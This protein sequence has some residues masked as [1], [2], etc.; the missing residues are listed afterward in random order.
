MKPEEILKIPEERV[1]ELL[2][3]GFKKRVEV[4]GRAF[5]FCSII[6]AKSGI[7]NGGCAFCAQA[8]PKKTKAPVYPLVDVEEMVEGALKAKEAKAVKYSIVTSGK[9]LSEKEFEKIIDAVKAIKSRV[10]IDVDVSLGIIPED[11]LKELKESGVRRVHHNLE[12]SKEFYPRITTK[13]D[14]QKKFSFAKKVKEAGLEL[15]CGGLF[16][17]G[18]SERDWV[19]LAESLKELEPE[20]IPI[21]FLIPIPG[22]PLENQKP[23]PP[24]KFLKL[25]LYLRFKFP[26]AELR[27]CG[28][29]EASLRETLTLAALVVN[30]FM[31]GGYLT[32]PGRDPR[33]DQKLVEDLGFELITHPQNR[34]EKG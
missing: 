2:S 15:C 8:F 6:N 34:R 23:Y 18:E 27:L 14:W 31:V 7:C 30:G 3:H 9:S 28:G 24:L 12:T 22:T 19:K 16:G 13:I 4:W 17:M 10:D 29:R 5:E 32:R 1:C 33:L 26:E 11:F 21:N 25:L 20:S